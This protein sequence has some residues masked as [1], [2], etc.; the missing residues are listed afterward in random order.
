MTG[1]RTETAAYNA[2]HSYIGPIAL[3]VVALLT[4]RPTLA[5]AGLVWAAHTGFDRALGYGLKYATG[6]GHT[7]LGSIG[8]SFGRAA[9]G[10]G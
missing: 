10:V 5:A 6:F 1:P 4:V 2:T 8:N 9:R 3:A 7:H